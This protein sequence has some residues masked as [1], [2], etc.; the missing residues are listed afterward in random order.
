M[1]LKG[2]M[3]HH[4]TNFVCILILCPLKL[5]LQKGSQR[6]QSAIY[7]LMGHHS[8]ELLSFVLHSV[9]GFKQASDR[10]SEVS[11]WPPEVSEWLSDVSER[12]SVVS[13]RH[14]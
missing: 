10:I 11:D 9:I 3:T 5:K 2:P 1:A 8:E 6:L 4:K 14:L 13:D 12:L 7:F